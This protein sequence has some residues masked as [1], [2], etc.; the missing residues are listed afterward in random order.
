M[1]D[2]TRTI[3]KYFWCD[4]KQT[5]HLPSLYLLYL[6][7]NVHFWSR[8]R[9]ISMWTKMAIEKVPEPPS[10]HGHLNVQLYKQQVPLREIQKWLGDS[11]TL[12]KYENSHTIK[13]GGNAEMHSHHRSHQ[14]W[15]KA[16]HLGWNPQLPTS[17]WRTKNLD[18]TS[19]IQTFKAPTEGWDPKTSSSE[20]Q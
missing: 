15:H 8:L 1:K 5:F 18:H 16:I 3:F 19:S 6:P 13:T 12:S 20:R 10:C 17:P 7:W 14:P 9:I 4:T 2:G 11:Y